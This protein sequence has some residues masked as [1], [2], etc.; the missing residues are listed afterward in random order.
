M[1]PTSVPD[2]PSSWV[3]R[4]ARLIPPDG[5]V[6]D[7]ACGR[8]RHTRWL[9]E[10]GHRVLAADIDVSGVEDLRSHRRA[11]IV[12][13]DL[14]TETWPFPDRQFGAVVMVNYL[15][16]PLFEILARSL[17]PGGVLIIDTFATGNECLGRPRNPDYLLRPGE[18]QSCFERSLDIIAYEHGFQAEPR[19]AIRQQLCAMKP[20]TTAGQ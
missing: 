10:Q 8:G 18:L 3:K 7:L 17:E 2:P 9:L 20:R 19:P 1:H 14:E 15:H 13:A 5:Q 12:Q 16:R 4:F 6:L 11:E